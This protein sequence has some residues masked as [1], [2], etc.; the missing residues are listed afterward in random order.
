MFPSTTYRH[1]LSDRFSANTHEDSHYLKFQAFLSLSLLS[2]IQSLFFFL[3]LAL[4]NWKIL[5]MVG[6]PNTMA[7]GGNNHTVFLSL[8][9]TTFV[10][11]HM[12]HLSKIFS[13][14][15]KGFPKCEEG[16]M[17]QKCRPCMMPRCCSSCF[18]PLGCSFPLQKGIGWMRPLACNTSFQV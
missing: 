11:G 10:P 18:W 7:L 15:C 16:S 6:Q 17:F 8:Q 3:R 2:R 1:P 5:E 13:I 9:Q 4:L 12:C 14:K